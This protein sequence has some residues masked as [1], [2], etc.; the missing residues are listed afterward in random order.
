MELD[1]TEIWIAKRRKQVK[2][3]AIKLMLRREMLSSRSSQ[4][5]KRYA[6]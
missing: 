4:T 5:Q 6:S 2:K 3:D 1:K